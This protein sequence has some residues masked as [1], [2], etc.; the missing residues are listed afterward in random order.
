MSR[1]TEAETTEYLGDVGC[2]EHDQDILRELSQRLEAVKRYDQYI[3]H[4]DWRE[5]LASFWTELKHQEQRN[6]MRLKELL[7]E[8]VRNECI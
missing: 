7:A 5:S 1:R 3:A 6:I 4:A 2:A 8:E